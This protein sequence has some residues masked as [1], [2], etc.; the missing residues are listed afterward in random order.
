MYY[1]T[2]GYQQLDYQIAGN[3]MMLHE[4]QMD[5]TQQRLENMNLPII[6]SECSPWLFFKKLAIVVR[7]DGYD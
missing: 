2:N 3:P 1:D 4:E 6:L 5:T 7:S